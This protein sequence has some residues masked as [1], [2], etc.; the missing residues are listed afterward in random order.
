MIYRPGQVREI[1]P[2]VPENVAWFI[3]GGPMLGDEAQVFKKRFTQAKVIGFEPNPAAFDYQVENDFPG[4]L[5]KCALWDSVGEVQFKPMGDNGYAIGAN[6]EWTGP[7]DGV[8][9]TMPV[10]AVTL[11]K[12]LSLDNVHDAVLWLDV[13]GSELRALRGAEG[14]LRGKQIVLINVELYY[15]D[16]ENLEDNEGVHGY[17]TGLGYEVAHRWNGAALS[18]GVRYDVVYKIKEQS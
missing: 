8:G 15:R 11:D 9:D 7:R 1:F 18:D 13:E 5:L 16:R 2:Y 3:V 17:L 4:Q 10:H 12:I 14:L 6:P